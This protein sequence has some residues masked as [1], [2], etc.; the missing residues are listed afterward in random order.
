MIAA[1]TEEGKDKRAINQ[2]EK[3]Y[4]TEERKKVYIA[5]ELENFIWDKEDVKEL[6]LM[7]KNGK[8]DLEIAAYF[9]RP[10]VDIHVLILDR[11]LKG[12]IKE[13]TN[14]V[15]LKPAKKVVS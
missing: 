12:K 15:L 11:L 1:Q 5:L 14:A 4:M 8:S 10:W 7:Y 6:D 2:I 3:Q 9:Q 13:R